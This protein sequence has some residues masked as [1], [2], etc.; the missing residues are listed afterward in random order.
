MSKL[1]RLAACLAAG[2]CL[3]STLSAHDGDLKLLH[4]KPMYPGTGWR[5]AQRGGSDQSMVSP[6]ITFPS[7]GVTLLSWISLPDFGVPTGGNGNSC[8]GYTSPSGREY[9]L[10]GLSTGTAFVEIT[11]PGNPVIVAQKTGPTSL[12]RDVRTF[13]HWAYCVSEG[14]GGIQVFDLVNIDS[15]VVTLVNTI[16]D[17]ST[18]A[19]HTITINQTSGYLYRSGGGNSGTTGLRIYNLNP[20][21]AAPQRVGTWSDRYC[22]ETSVFNY[23]SGPAAG[24]EIAYVCGG[25]N[26]GF[27]STGVYVVDVTNH[28][29]PTTIKY[30]TYPNAQFC[31]QIWPSADMQWLYSDDELDDENLGIT[32]VMRVFNNSNPLNVTFTGTYTNGNTSVDHNLYTKNNTIFQSAYRSGLR[33]YTTTSPGTPSSPVEIGYFDT[34]PEDDSTYFNGLWNNYPYFPSG[35]VIGSDIEKGLFVWWVGTP[36]LTF[37]F[38]GGAPTVV[39]PSGQTFALQINESSPGTL[40]AG[41]AQFHYNTGSGWNTVSLVPN[42]GNN[43]SATF[44]S[45]PCGTLIDYYVT[46]QSQ[47]GVIWSDPPG[48]NATSYQA[49]AAASQVTIFSDDFE[50]NLGW[51]AGVT[52]D[53]ATAGIW[54]RVNPVASEIAP[55]NDHSPGGTMCYVTG[56]GVPGGGAGDNDVDNGKTTLLS[57]VFDLSSV[58]QPSI[59]YWRWYANHQLQGAAGNDSFRVDV[60]NNNGASWTNVETVGPGGFETVGGWIYHEFPVASFVTPT[61]QVRVRFIAEDQGTQGV[62]E[63]GIDDVRVLATNCPMGGPTSFC[64]GDGSLVTPCPCSNF[65]GAGRGCDNSAATGGAL[66]SSS[67][68]TSPDTLVLSQVGE[69]G[70][71]SSVFLQGDATSSSG[72]TFGDGV[73]CVAGS[74]KRLYTKSASSGSA[75]APTG[76]D[77]SISARSAALGDPIAPGSTRYY[78]VYYRDANLSFCPAPQGDS[79]NVGNGLVVNW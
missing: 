60:T 8:Y 14:G 54:T 10:M 53:T 6:P 79:W 30:I 42:G 73:R 70:S 62:V 49:V 2:L 50:T 28:A 72:I 65:G 29:A 71:S 63:A 15:G 48:T 24:K 41:T 16:N 1:L 56:Q 33:I 69:I 43:F 44:P 40:Q 78:Q 11:Q 68:T 57:P 77:P 59:G 45:T 38:T 76:G 7:N 74:L 19:T 67:G 32:S 3:V 47:N 61:A 52:G 55:E 13:Q 58:S 35:V 9:A 36:A 21:P 5:N 25:L 26:G 37:S 17:D 4:K 46:A 12:W 39:S 34:W 64:F 20:N 51:T 31:H 27:N 22:H 66:L 18:S 23:T 75:T